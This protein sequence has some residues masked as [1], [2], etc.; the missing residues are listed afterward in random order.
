MWADRR[1]LCF[2]LVL[3]KELHNIIRICMLF[4]GFRVFLMCFE[5]KKKVIHSQGTTISSKRPLL[6]HCNAIGREMS[7]LWAVFWP[8]TVCLLHLYRH[9]TSTSGSLR[10]LSLK[11]KNLRNK[12]IPFGEEGS[13]CQNLLIVTH[14]T[15]NV[16]YISL[17]ILYSSSFLLCLFHLS[18]S[19]H[20]VNF[21]LLFLLSSFHA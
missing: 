14:L 21:S 3:A 19:I 5:W 8:T 6:E 18:R 16:V 10:V 20:S 7:N 12:T 15:C 11:K 17:L 9:R 4:N 13:H 2:H 1:A